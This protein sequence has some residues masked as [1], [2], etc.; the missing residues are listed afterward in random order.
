MRLK[1]GELAKRA[2]LTV[3]TLHHYDKIGLL[4]PSARSDSGY[5]L[6]DGDDIARLY[7]VQALRRLDLSL[8]DI[9]QLLKGASSD[10]H[11]VIEQQI[12]GLERQIAQ[13]V[14]LRDRLR[15]LSKQLREEREPS[16]DYWL[17]TLEMMSMYG[18]YFTAAEIEGLRR[19]KEAGAGNSG[20]VMQPIVVKMRAL[21]DGGMSPRSPQAQELAKRWQQ[22][23]RGVM[24]EDPRMFVKLENMHRNEPSVQSLTGVDGEMID[25]VTAALVE[26]QYGIFAQYL[27]EEELK[28]FR[29]AHT[30]NAKQWIV[31]FATARQ[32]M[33]QAVA[34][35]HPDAQALAQR[36]IALGAETWGGDPATVAKVRKIYDERPELGASS[37]M[38]PEMRAYM[39]QAAAQLKREE[40]PKEGQHV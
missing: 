1:I 33:E 14:E 39:Q 19:R 17:T 18:K 11:G 6:Y 8:A 10:L 36:W 25:Y 7:R 9:A 24:G 23:M 15:S 3:R 40:N 16:L 13:A 38:T 29:T 31:V 32:Y 5:R 37:G 20:L 12:V 35:E 22:I 28:D 2:G 30:R 26:I 21:M 27:T 34:P 4:K